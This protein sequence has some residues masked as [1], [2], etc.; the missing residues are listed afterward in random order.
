MTQRHRP[1]FIVPTE[2]SARHTEHSA[3]HTEH[4]ARH[5]EHLACLTEHFVYKTVLSTLT[6]LCLAIPQVYT[7]RGVDFHSLHRQPFTQAQLICPCK[8]YKLIKALREVLYVSNGT[9][10]CQHPP[11]FN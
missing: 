5:T 9:Q 7:G 3:R 1:F 6:V 11:C 10:V 8:N 2:H 4:S